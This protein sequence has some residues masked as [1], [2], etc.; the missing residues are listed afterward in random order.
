MIVV[1]AKDLTKAYGTDVILDK[2]SFHINKGDRVG[3]IGINGAGK[4]TLLKMLTG[5][6]S[7]ESGDYFISADTKIGYLKQDGEF[8]S[9]NT[10]IE[11]VDRIFDRFPKME[12]EMERLLQQIESKEIPDEILLEK[13]DALQEE[14]KQQGGYTYKSEITGIL[15]SMA[16]GEESYGKKISS[17]SG[18]ER[19]R[20]AL[21]CLLLKKPDILFLDEPTNH[22]DI[23]TLKWL[24]QYLKNYNGTIV[25]VSHD[26]YFLD[27]TV[28]RIFEIKNHKLTIYEGNYSFYATERKVR[29]EAEF[30]KFEKQQKEIRRQEDMIR[31]FKQRGTEKLAKR[32]ASREKRLAAMDV[33]DRPDT[34]HGRLKLNFHENFQSGKDVLLLENLSKKFAYDPGEG[35]LSGGGGRQLFQHVDLDVKRGERICIVGANGIGKTTLL[36]MILGETSCTT[37]RIRIGHNVQFG[38]YDQ[39]QQLLNGSNTVIGELQDAYRLYNDTEMRNILGR[40]LFRGESVF[41]QIS[42][43]SGGEKARLALLKLMLS[44]ANVLILDEPT[45]H[46]DIESK[47]VFE[48]ALLDFPGTSII[49]S[50]DRYFLNRIPTRIVELTENGMDSYLG[51]YDYYV[52]KKQAQIQSGK[53]YMDE[54][55]SREKAQMDAPQSA[56]QDSAKDTPEG[57]SS[58]SA[59]EQR[60]LKK[61]QE[62]K[63]RRIRRQKESLEADIAS[64]ENDISCLEAELCLEENMKDHVKLTALSEELADKKGELELKYEEW[65]IL[66][67]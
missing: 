59:A 57:M 40:F 21:A 36:K 67:E 45:N 30:R 58:L 61:E 3:I 13:Y 54:L 26:R 27:Q 46:L 53:K 29:R 37:G 10:V 35:V 14:Y 52:E 47:E 16:F 25:L 63:D 17:L 65:L 31:R 60:K 28:N 66:Q 42:S 15:S 19:T 12:Q 48:E 6:M 62:A 20:L 39:G 32:A 18:G 34:D 44:G 23:G 7:C 24:E 9:E 33:M 50:H 4:S 64:L 5:E 2:V 8:E 51:T 49:V 55:S 22:L 41:L 38:Y 1:S 56:L 11:E 43:L